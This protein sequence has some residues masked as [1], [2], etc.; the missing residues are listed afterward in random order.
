MEL[1]PESDK[2][3]SSW[4]SPRTEATTCGATRGQR[5]PR[6]DRG[7]F[8][9]GYLGGSPAPL[10]G[11][12]GGRG[13]GGGG[14]GGVRVGPV[15]PVGEAVIGVVG[16]GRRVEVLHGAEV[17]G[18]DGLEGRRPETSL[19]REW[20]GKTGE[21]GGLERRERMRT[22]PSEVT[23]SY[24]PPLGSEFLVRSTSAPSLL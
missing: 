15:K 23:F 6:A 5:A 9:R 11:G 19:E 22:N 16:R 2:L 18:G 21:G 12:R 17:L 13:R 24:F 8:F 3:S 14:F 10:P 4:L 1:W 20:N 7:G